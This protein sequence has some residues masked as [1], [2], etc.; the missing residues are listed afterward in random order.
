MVARAERAWR[1]ELRSVSIADLV[2]N[3]AKTVHPDAAHKGAAWF[4]E[5]AR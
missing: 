1:D 4:Q 3:L 5:V 2:D